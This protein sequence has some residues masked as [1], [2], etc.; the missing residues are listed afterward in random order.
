VNNATDAKIPTFLVKSLESRRN[1]V[2][3]RQAEA[4]LH[5]EV[6]DERIE[7]REFDEEDRLRVDRVIK[8]TVFRGDAHERYST[9]V[10]DMRGQ[11]AGDTDLATRLQEH[12]DR[13]LRSIAA[14]EN[15]R[16]DP[17]GTMNRYADLVPSEHWPTV[18]CMSHHPDATEK[19][20]DRL[21]SQ[22]FPLHT[23]ELLEQ[24]GIVKLSCPPEMSFA[25]QIADL[26]EAVV[27]ADPLTP[28]TVPHPVTVTTMMVESRQILGITPDLQAR[29]GQDIVLAV[30]DTGVDR[31]HPALTRI[32]G[33]DYRDFTLSGEEDVDGH[34][35]HVASIA[36]GDETSLG[37]KYSGIAPRCRLVVGKVL[38][39][40]RAGNLE[41]I[42]QGMAW[43]VVEKGADILS[44]SLGEM[45][46][47]PNGQSIWS[48][49]CGE[50][51][52][53]GTVVC[54]AAGNPMPSYPE[55]ICVPADCPTTVTVGAIDK[56]ERLAPFSALG[57]PVPSSP[58][59]GKPNCVGPGVDVVAARSSTADFGPG[60]VVGER[61][62]RLSGTSMAT[63]AIAGCLALL[64]SMVRS[65]GREPAPAD[66]VD[67]FYSACRP[68]KDENGRQYDTSMQIGHGLIDMAEALREAR[69][70]IEAQTSS[71][72]LAKRPPVEPETGRT[73][74]AKPI[75]PPQIPVFQ[76]GPLQADVCYCCGKRYLT[77]M[78]IFSP[79]W[80]C[81]RC[82]API[83]RVCWQIG[84]RACEKHRDEIPSAVK[85]PATQTGAPAAVTFEDPVLLPS[86]AAGFPGPGRAAETI[87]AMTVTDSQPPP[88]PAP[89]RSWGTTF[90]NRFELKVRS[91][92]RVLHPRSKEEFIV[93]PNLQP[94]SFR[95][96]FGDV[97][98]FSLQ[99][100]VILRSRVNLTAIRLDPEILVSEG[101]VRH[102]AND[103]L[104]RIMGPDGLDFVGEH[105]YCV[106]IFSD[107]GWPE[108][109]RIH[110]EVRGNA[111]FYL[112][113]KGKGTS[114]I[115]SGRQDPLRDLFDPE[116]GEEKKTRAELALKNHARLVMSGDSVPMDSFLSEQHLDRPSILAAI[117]T[118]GGRFQILEYKGKSYIQRSTR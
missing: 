49:A 22:G 47:T 98:Q 28:V 24:F 80:E 118:A 26:P 107:A 68:L 44:L 67:L 9:L 7:E 32:S 86:H 18:L 54:V 102:D 23:A 15:V 92:G 63:P 94:Q 77:K 53:R 37:G 25:R 48:K 113:E 4:A 20:K 89:L 41:S 35:T 91:A 42:L 114:W 117:E 111:L 106:G 58:L 12:L 71:S 43:A 45:D 108:A 75:T 66:L 82:G 78:D 104:Q 27:V 97:T 72:R 99:T 90:M 74:C 76:T 57:S 110:E 38:S 83:C 11:G 62:V 93:D 56:H 85:Y 103:L 87:A 21:A 16:S 55:S 6:I 17:G 60:E 39:P 51:F 8:R 52:R 88:L 59:F 112:V 40:G 33:E 50:A 46:T 34:G 95:R 13:D 100:G 96:A 5:F 81:A 30:L 2:I 109:W 65:L 19:L 69:R 115:V 36:G 116:N 31:S 10:F 1:Q 29:F 84:H 73:E 105:F 70:H 79:A 61:H 101:S 3:A 14:P 64:K